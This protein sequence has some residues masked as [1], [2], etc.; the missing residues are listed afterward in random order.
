MA[1]QHKILLW[2]QR[3]P[4]V[5]RLLAV[6][7]GRIMKLA[8]SRRESLPGRFAVLSDRV[9]SDQHE[10][11][12]DT[13]SR[14]VAEHHS[15][16]PEKPQRKGR[17]TRFVHWLV[18]LRWPE[19]GLK[20]AWWRL[21]LKWRLVFALP[22]AGL[23]L[24]LA[25]LIA[26]MVYYTIA[27][28]HPMAIR[29]ADETTIRVLGR[30]GTVL[31]ERGGALDY[32][33]ISELPRHLQAAVVATEDRR[34]FDHHGLDPIGLARAFF[35]NLRAARFVQGGSTLTQQLAKNLFLTS[36]RT[37]ARKVEELALALWLELRLSKPEI[38][39]LY[40]NSV[41]FGAGAY[42][43][44]AASQKYFD[45]PA[46]DLT[47]PQSAVIAG[48]LKAPSR[49]SPS[50]NPSLARARGRVVINAM[51][52]AGFI[53]KDQAHQALGERVVFVVTKSSR[54]T[55]VANYAVD[56]VLENLPDAIEKGP[57]ELI[58]ETTIDPTLQRRSGEMLRQTL[59][60]DGKSHK[61]GQGAVVVIDQDG[62]I[63]ALAGGRDY[64]KS[65][66]NRAVSARRQPGSAFKPIVYLA[67][68][69]DGLTPDSPVVDVPV[70]YDGWSPSNN[71][72][73]YLGLID[74]RTAMARSV[75]TVAAML[76]S[77]AGP[78]RTIDAAR[79][80]GITSSLREDASLAL[81]TS[82]VTPLEIATAYAVLGNGGFS[83]EPYIIR[84]VR[85][86]NGRVLFTRKAPQRRRVVNAQTISAMNDLLTASVR[87]GTGKRAAL[88]NHP[89]AGKTGTSQDYRD[90]W[91][92]GY[93][94]YLAAAVW[95]GNDD[96][97]PMRK[98]AGGGLPANLW[99]R[100]MSAGHEGL[101]P[102]SL[103]GSQDK[104]SGTPTR[105][106]G[107]VATYVA[108]QVAEYRNDPAGMMKSAKRASEQTK[109][110]PALSG[111]PDDF[112]AR[113]LADAASL[114]AE[115]SGHVGGN[116]P[117]SPPSRAQ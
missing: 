110:A 82:E 108:R 53:S 17:L 45:R 8:A 35:A 5:G 36:E 61:A 93:S 79:Q 71:A 1:Q 33:S 11:T 27:F 103:P 28:P 106:L 88:A 76:H 74:I 2:L 64:A 41:Y 78:Q 75:N 21:S 6:V 31:A 67:A 105:S 97:T 59:D 16:Q 114:Q 14:P 102:L 80:L 23:T 50:R 83:I 92:A 116:A 13:S 19:G 109:R 100:V 56:Y 46:R 12:T 32:T 42:G 95:I 52:D 20:G 66:F 104:A 115:A 34:F 94:S 10:V 40:L 25:G 22:I 77:A 99:R 111:I 55:S 70:T 7:V 72:G 90:A 85:E 68:L 96:G 18:S 113:A 73:K 30:D 4:L 84:R 44:E 29:T 24:A 38:L 51:L 58:I 91:F 48:L 87:E 60:R 69:D 57:R 101:S 43:V 26:I 39:E 3:V 81:G 107:P 47:L 98:A 65:Q 9:R 86:A 117:Q 49:Y 63:R 54:N 37:L 89:V 62:G 112:I 15:T